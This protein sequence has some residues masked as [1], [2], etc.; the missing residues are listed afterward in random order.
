MAQTPTPCSN[1][2]D[3]LEPAQLAFALNADPP[4]AVDVGDEVTFEADITNVNG[5]LAH[6]PAFTLIDSAQLF[7]VE[8]IESGGDVGNEVTVSV[9]VLSFVHTAPAA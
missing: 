7:T 1:G 4:D 6:L 8:E 2:V 9:D 3:P 5:G